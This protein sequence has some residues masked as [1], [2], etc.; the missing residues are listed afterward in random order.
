MSSR[1]RSRDQ[2]PAEISCQTATTANAT[3]VECQSMML[4]EAS[5]AKTLDF[6][7]VSAID[8]TQRENHVSSDRESVEAKSSFHS[9]WTGNSEFELPN[10]P[11]A[12]VS[13]ARFP[14]REKYIPLQQAESCDKAVISVFGVSGCC[15]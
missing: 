13:A 7:V 2:S 12:I 5:G 4:V 15:H 8:I 11:P 14:G 10:C 3:D 1:K 9:N 6:N